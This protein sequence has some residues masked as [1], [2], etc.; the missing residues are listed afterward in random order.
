MNVPLISLTNLNSLWHKPG[1]TFISLFVNK[2]SRLVYSIK[3]A[4][5]ALKNEYNY[6]SSQHPDSAIFYIDMDS[7]AENGDLV[8]VRDIKKQKFKVIDWSQSIR[9]SIIGVVTEVFRS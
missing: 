9:N 7:K 1:R 6:F 8:F 5:F 3:P 4:T 2:E